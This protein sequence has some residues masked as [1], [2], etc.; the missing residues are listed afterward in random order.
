MQVNDQ[1]GAPVWHSPVNK[2]TDINLNR[3]GSISVKATD[4]ILIHPIEASSALHPVSYPR[5]FPLEKRWKSI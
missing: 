3:R 5:V 1:F 4:Y 2:V